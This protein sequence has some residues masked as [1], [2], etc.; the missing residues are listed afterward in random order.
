MSF[1]TSS[2]VTPVTTLQEVHQPMVLL[3]DEHGDIVPIDTTSGTNQI[4]LTIPDIKIYPN[5][6]TDYLIINQGEI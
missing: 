5:P 4:D 3:I 2:P 1:T 6:A